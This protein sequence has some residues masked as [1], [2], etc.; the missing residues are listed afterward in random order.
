MKLENKEFNEYYNINMIRVPHIE[1]PP[2]YKQALKLL[3]PV[4]FDVVFQELYTLE[5]AAQF[6]TK[7]EKWMTTNK[8]KIDNIDEKSSK[9]QKTV[10]G[11]TKVNQ[12][13]LIGKYVYQFNIPYTKID[14]LYMIRT[15]QILHNVNYKIK[16]TISNKM[17]LI[18]ALNQKKRNTNEE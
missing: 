1:P 11:S 4:F 16:K 14:D 9:L 6:L 8:F 7:S 10:H 5:A 15:N 2:S 18:I 3:N 12:N 17:K 13:A